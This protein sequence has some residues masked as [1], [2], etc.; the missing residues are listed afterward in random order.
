MDIDKFIS[1]IIEKKQIEE[2]DLICVFRMAKEVLFEEGTL[3]NIELP[4]TIVGDIH[5]QFYDLLK[6]FQV[7]GDPSST[8]YLFLGD[9]VDRGYY[10]IECFALL[11]A[12]KIKYPTSFYMLR[13]NHECRQ[14]NTMYGFYDE[15]VQ[16]FGHSGPWKLFNEV[17]DMLPMAALV[18][19]SIYCIHGGLSPDIKLA[20]QV[21]LFERRQE[22]PIEGPLADIVWSDPEDIS[23]WGNNP[24]GA[25]YLYGTRPTHEFL[26]NNK[27]ELIARAHQLMN[28]GYSY[29]FN[30]TSLI[31]VW[32]AP[33]YMYRAGNLASVLKINDDHSRKPI[34]FD[35]APPSVQTVPGDRVSPYFL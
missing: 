2:R 7:S 25:G 19:N 32:S 4:I 29:H 9:Y 26:H 31:T 17:F 21:S 28:E 8:R 33:N 35:A 5:G 11:I 16:R 18:S 12:Y 20:D 14:V 3:L 34:I 27:I 23:G 22:L 10:S 1:D 6:L 24:R 13:G 15:N 30:E